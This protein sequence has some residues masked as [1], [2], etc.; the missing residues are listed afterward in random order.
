MKNIT[1]SF[2]EFPQWCVNIVTAG[3]G[4]CGELKFDNFECGRVF[5]DSLE[6]CIVK[7]REMISSILKL[8]PEEAFNIHQPFAIFKNK[9]TYGSPIFYT[10]VRINGRMSVSI[11]DFQNIKTIHFTDMIDYV[12]EMEIVEEDIGLDE[13]II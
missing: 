13:D 2:E 5:G 10:L 11:Y 6:R 4:F 7:S 8:I 12:K 9:G 3:K 1:V